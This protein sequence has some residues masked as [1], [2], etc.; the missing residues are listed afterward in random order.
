LLHI[1]QI[2][3]CTLVAEQEEALEEVRA[4]RIEVSQDLLV[5]FEH[6]RMLTLHA[7]PIHPNLQRNHEVVKNSLLFE[8][9]GQHQELPSKRKKKMTLAHEAVKD[10]DVDA[11]E[12]QRAQAAAAVKETLNRIEAKREERRCQVI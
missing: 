10:V 5:L 11:E 1:L 6:C 4:K 9:V 2:N 8:D 3:L 12:H 7:H